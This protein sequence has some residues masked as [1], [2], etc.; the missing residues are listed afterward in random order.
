MCLP[1]SA[2]LGELLK[3]AK[4]KWRFPH[5]ILF[6]E[7]EKIELLNVVPTEDGKQDLHEILNTWHME[8]F[9][10]AVAGK[11]G[12]LICHLSMKGNKWLWYFKISSSWG[13]RRLPHK[14]L[15]STLSPIQLLRFYK[16]KWSRGALPLIILSDNQILC[17][18][19]RE[20]L[21]PLICSVAECVKRL[22]KQITALTW[23]LQVLQTPG[24]QITAE[25]IPTPPPAMTILSGKCIQLHFPYC[26]LS[27]I[28]CAEFIIFYCPIPFL[29][30][31]QV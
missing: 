13:N 14:Q 8:H 28:Y 27:D 4:S 10:R 18:R 20:E 3:N 26:P 21:K 23:Y 12:Q 7:W 29:C 25:Q 15:T 31:Q 30:R 1:V 24:R 16:V 9:F 19:A 6:A 17:S 11:L 22:G 2:C 5:V